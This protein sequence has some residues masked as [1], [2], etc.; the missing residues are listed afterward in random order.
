MPISEKKF[1]IFTLCNCISNLQII[2]EITQGSVT[3][4]GTAVIDDFSHSSDLDACK[5]LPPEA[6]PM[7]TTP[8]PSPTTTPQ[9]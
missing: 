9:M 5:V 8:K 6:D 3:E 2:V 4:I 1:L 7:N